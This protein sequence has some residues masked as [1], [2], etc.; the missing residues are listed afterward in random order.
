ML[1]VSIHATLAGGDFFGWL[2][3]PV[4]PSFYPRHPRGW[5]HR[6]FVVPGVHAGVSIHATLAGGDL[7]KP[8]HLFHSST[9]V[10]IHATLAGGDE[11]VPFALCSASEFLSTPPSR[12]ATEV[13]IYPMNGTERFYPRHPRGWRRSQIMGSAGLFSCFYPRHPRGWRLAGFEVLPCVIHRFYPRH[14]RGWR[15]YVRK[16][17]RRAIFVSIHATLA[18]GDPV[19][20]YAVPLMWL[21]LSTPPSRV[22]TGCPSPFLS[23]S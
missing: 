12:V 23:D 18:G 9:N 3:L 15:R 20:G 5:R 10:S 4:I 14:P 6:K 8:S 21:F 19:C 16:L 13:E 1:P 2:N 17:H 11:G 22:A 7:R